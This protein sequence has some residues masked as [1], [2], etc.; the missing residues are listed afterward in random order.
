MTP[1]N[2]PFNQ[3]RLYAKI[4][5]KRFNNTSTKI[6]TELSTM[7]TG[8]DNNSNVIADYQY[9]YR[10]ILNI[11]QCFR[12]RGHY[13]AHLDPL[14]HDACS[15]I[16][17]DFDASYNNGKVPDIVQ[18]L[19][20]YNRTKIS[21]SSSSSSS[22]ST[23]SNDFTSDSI[24]AVCKQYDLSV[25][26]DNDKIHD[27][28]R[29]IDQALFNIHDLNLYYVSNSSHSRSNNNGC[30]RIDNRSNVST[31][32]Y[33]SLHQI[34]EALI[35]TY[36][37]KVGIEI[38]HIEDPQQ[39]QWLLQQIERQMMTHYS[40]SSSLSSSRW[41]QATKSQQLENIHRLIK[42]DHSASFIKRKYP[43]SKVFGI[44]GCESLI[45]G[46]WALIQRGCFKWGVEGVELGMWVWCRCLMILI[47]IIIKNRNHHHHQS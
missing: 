9:L 35:R 19:Y 41:C 40:P 21:S 38:S 5:I 15:R 10:S 32:I 39:K 7:T 37:N 6:S 16:G 29:I 25:F 12:D 34:I 13:A 14:K 17:H 46:V 30:N 44:E 33:Y 22:S 31:E 2:Y 11:I 8:L 43:S 23:I 42:V 36:C 26:I 18:F 47:I 45:P 3:V 4:A 20:N 28:N 24:D 1:L 27:V